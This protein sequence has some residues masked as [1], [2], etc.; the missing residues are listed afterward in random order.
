MLRRLLAWVGAVSRLVVPVV[1]EAVVG[2]GLEDEGHI[3]AHC[4]VVLEIPTDQRIQQVGGCSL[5]DGSHVLWKGYWG[6][7]LV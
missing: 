7:R 2:D 4:Q 1:Q 6:G 5:N 3:V